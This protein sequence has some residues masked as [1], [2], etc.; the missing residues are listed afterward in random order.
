MAHLQIIWSKHDSLPDHD[1]H[2]RGSAPDEWRLVVDRRH[3]DV[4]LLC[5]RQAVLDTAMRSHV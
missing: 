2:T 3:R 4:E 1:L 5:H